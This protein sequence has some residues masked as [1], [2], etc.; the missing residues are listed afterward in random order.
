MQRKETLWQISVGRAS[1]VSTSTKLECGRG[2][3]LVI[4]TSSGLDASVWWQVL[5]PHWAT[6]GMTKHMPS[7]GYGPNC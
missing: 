4:Q 7:S 1:C 3:V 6:C 2:I 5:L